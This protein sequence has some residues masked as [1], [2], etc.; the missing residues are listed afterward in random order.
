M[1][2]NK[3]FNPMR[4]ALIPEDALP[5][6]NPELTSLTGLTSRQRRILR[7]ATPAIQEVIDVKKANGALFF[8]LLEAP[9]KII[10]HYD[11][12]VAHMY[13]KENL[14]LFDGIDF[15]PIKSSHNIKNNK[16]HGIEWTCRSI[17][18]LIL[19]VML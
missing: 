5:P 13:S 19:R 15:E 9:G 4:M 14:P 12:L 16:S 1:H 8:R 18:N 2:H 10:V 3:N 7:I 17:I 6:L 11:V